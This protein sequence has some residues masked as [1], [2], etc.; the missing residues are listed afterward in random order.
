MRAGVGVGVVEGVSGRAAVWQWHWKPFA[1]TSRLHFL[2]EPP[3]HSCRSNEARGVGS[4]L[5]LRMRGS[6]WTMRSRPKSRHRGTLDASMSHDVLREGRLG[7]VLQLTQVF[8]PFLRWSK[9]G[10]IC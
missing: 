1:S 10:R 3:P 6:K 7:K 9:S 5:V 4:P 2:T 8:S